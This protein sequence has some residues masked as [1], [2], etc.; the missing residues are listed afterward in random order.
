MVKQMKKNIRSKKI[1]EVIVELIV[2]QS[3]ET[4]TSNICLMY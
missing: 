3:I 4:I 1:F 2:E